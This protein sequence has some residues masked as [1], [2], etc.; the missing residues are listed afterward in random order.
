LGPRFGLDRAAFGGSVLSFVAMSMM[1]AAGLT[2]TAIQPV[3]S[4]CLFFY[5]VA[6]GL[7]IANVIIGAVRAAGPYSGAATGLCGAL[8]M[9]GSAALGSV[10]IG[11][12]GDADFQLAISICWIVV[13]VGLM[14]AFL[15][16]DRPKR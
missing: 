7:V 4:F 14:S 5:G 2:G 13:T 15:A 10:I 9:A 12:G 3:I 6:N 16:L 11:F 8:Q 1:L